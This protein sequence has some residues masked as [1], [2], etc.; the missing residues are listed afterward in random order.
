MVP[1][2][3]SS[4]EVRAPVRASSAGF[5]VRD[6]VWARRTTPGRVTQTSAPD[7]RATRMAAASFALAPP[8]TSVGVFSKRI[9]G[10]G[11]DDDSGGGGG[12]DVDEGTTQASMSGTTET[13]RASMSSPI[14]ADDIGSTSMTRTRFTLS[15]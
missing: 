5:V 1:R 14:A 7:A 15:S 10:G 11:D 2:N 12:A 9:D 4:R 13:T 6:G 3:G 8:V